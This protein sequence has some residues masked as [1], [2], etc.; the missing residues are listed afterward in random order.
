M[1]WKGNRSLAI[2]YAV[3]PIWKLE[4]SDRAWLREHGFVLPE[5]EV[6]QPALSSCETS[7][8]KSLLRMELEASKHLLGSSQLT[9]LASDATAACLSAY[10]KA[11]EAAW[12]VYQDSLLTYGQS[13][14]PPLDVLE[15]YAGSDSR[16][17]TWVNS[18]GGRA[19]RFTAQAIKAVSD[20]WMSWAGQPRQLYLDPA[21]EFRS[22][23]ILERW[24]TM[25]ARVFVTAA[26]WQ[27][28]RVER[29]GD[30]VKDM[31]ARMDNHSPLT[32]DTSFDEALL[33]AFQAKNALVRHQGYSPEQ[34]VL[35]KAVHVPG[36]LTS[37]ED[38]SSH[39]ATEGSDLEAERHRQ[40]LELRCQARKVFW[41]ADNNQVD[42]YLE[43][44]GV[45]GGRALVLQTIA[46]A[47]FPLS[48]FDIKTAFLRG[49]ADAANPLAMAYAMSKAVDMLGWMRALWG[50]I[51][52][53]QWLT[54]PPG[55]S[56]EE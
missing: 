13:I 27:R 15:V 2:S 36:S 33:Q 25:S 3:K 53:I 55:G 1:P 38:L 35:G 30:I 41:E 21:G 24:Q 9:N 8:L 44:P 29:H 11:E 34:I 32:N 18:M 10:R 49:K 52:A 39:A 45:S 28:G 48:S 42:P 14:E 46:S 4:A 5:T 23:E 16:L 50:V 26:A 47:Q 17:T 7:C 20:F 40:R 51:H 56:T 19:M 6:P 12:S 22:E 54:D 43:S 37:D 31:L